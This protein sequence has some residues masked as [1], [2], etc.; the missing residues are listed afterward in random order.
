MASV[1]ARH[2]RA[3]ALGKPWTPFSKE[4]LAG[5]SCQ[6]SFYVVVCEG[7]KLHR[8]RVGK[9]RQAAER[10]LRKI[11]TAVDEGVY[12]PQKAIRFTE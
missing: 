11:G 6:P 1:Q 12:M 5:C 8:E 7:R 10:A 2:S 4:R 9:D 3:C